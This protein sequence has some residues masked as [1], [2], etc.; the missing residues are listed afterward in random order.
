MSELLLT[1]A[2]SSS[3][4]PKSKGFRLFSA[5]ILITY[6]QCDKSPE[7]ILEFFK[8][9]NIEIEKYIIAQESHK[10]GNKHIHAYLL[11][12][13][14]LNTR[15]CKYFDFDGF[16]PKFEGCRTWKKVICYVTKEGNY[17]TNY[18]KD[19]IDKIILENMKPGEL[20]A[21]AR[22][23][24]EEKSVEEGL[25]VLNNVKTVRDL[26][27][28]G[29]A[30]ERNFRSLKRQHTEPK[31]T[32]DKFK[33]N[34]EWNQT[35]TLVLWGPT[36]TGKTSLAKALLPRALFVRHIDALKEYRTGKYVGIIFDDMSFKHWPREAQIHLVD[37]EN[38]SQI[39]V[40]H[41]IA[42]IP[43]GTPRI[44]CHN[45]MPAEILTIDIM[46]MESCPLSRRV[47]CEWIEKRCF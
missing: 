18:E 44:I 34:F 16:H 41:S 8:T 3:E 26:N 15:D 2:S 42:I 19:I 4:K 11:L 37:T 27:I 20:H 47:Q 10:D 1:E 28:H 24:A 45:S 13:N 39:N 23:V 7:N 30:I 6:S 25:E 9:K 22:K 17:I 38:V 21:K 33:A 5:Q 40:K 29:E 32:L 43:E 14:K 31:Y 12:K 35:R 46:N 36:N